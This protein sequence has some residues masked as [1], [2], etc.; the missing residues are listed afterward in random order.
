[1][2]TQKDQEYQREEK[3]K[4]VGFRCDLCGETISNEEVALG[5]TSRCEHCSWQVSPSRE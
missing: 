1:M 3:W 4:A 2:S 5:Y